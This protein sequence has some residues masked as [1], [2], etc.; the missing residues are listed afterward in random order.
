MSMPGI[1]PSDSVAGGRRAPQAL[2]PAAR[3]AQGAR[4]WR[5][6]RRAEAPMVPP[7]RFGSYYGKPVLNEPVW[8]ARDIA[9]YLFLGGL[10]G[11]SSLLAAGA[12]L[13]GR[14]RLAVAA[15]S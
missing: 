8:E 13:T 14:P 10:A 12:D 7:A 4:R 11:G 3:A 6:K 9:G 5:G 2:Q 15:K 1:S